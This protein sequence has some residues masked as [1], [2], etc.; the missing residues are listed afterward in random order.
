[1]ISNISAEETV[2]TKL[3]KARNSE[4]RREVIKVTD[5]VYTAVGYSVQPPS[6]IVG[7]RDF[8]ADFP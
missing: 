5:G 8:V 3:L 2:A 4:F 6:M 7:L 1:M